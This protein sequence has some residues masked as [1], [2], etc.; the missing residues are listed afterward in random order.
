MVGN[1]FGRRKYMK[2]LWKILLAVGI[3]AALTA[4]PASAYL[5]NFDNLAAQNALNGNIE[6]VNL[7]GFTITSAFNDST[8]IG[9]GAFGVGWV[10]PFNAVTNNSF[11]TNNPMTL[12]FVV[13]QSSVSFTGGDMGGDLDQFTVTAFDVN[14]VQLGQIVTPVFGG[15]AP[16][17]TI[18]VDQFTVQLNFLG[19][20]KTVVISNAINAG[21]GIDNVQFCE[22]PL[23]ASALLLGTG[24]VG[25]IG[26]RRRFNS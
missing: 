20:M 1:F 14:N 23:P 10:S 18:M 9:N 25:L 4:G 16:V 11:V 8:V 15:N 13:P 26:L 19:G 7:G 24:L 3:V 2:R 22:T 12:T 6:G 5:V 21:I 17:G